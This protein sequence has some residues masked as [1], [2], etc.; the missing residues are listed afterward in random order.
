MRFLNFCCA[1]ALSVTP[2]V[3]GAEDARYLAPLPTTVEQAF[4]G[5]LEEEAATADP[6]VTASRVEPACCEATSG[7]SDVCCGDACGD[8]CCSVIGGCGCQPANCGLLGLGYLTYD[9]CAQ[10][11]VLPELLLGC[12][13]HTEGCFDDFI[14]PMTNPVF[15][16]DPRNVTELRGVFINHNV[17]AAAGGGDIQL[18]AMQIRARLTDRLSLVAG[19]DGYIVSDNPLIDDGWADVDVGLKYALY[20]DAASQRLLSVG[21]AYDMPV[22]TP[23]ALQAG[24]DGAFHLYTTGGAQILDHGHWLS[25]LGGI[26]PADQDANSSFLYWSNHFDYQVRRGW[27]ALMEFNWYHWAVDGDNRLGLTG[28][29]GGDLFN[30]GSAGVAG[31]D[32]V[33]GA[34]GVKYKPNRL[35]ELGIAW[36][37][38]LT[39]RRDV[40]EDRLTIDAIFRY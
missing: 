1:T 39:D 31:N 19:K 14:S 33:T 11:C 37:N 6:V 29:E 24:G 22:G 34:F 30:F 18:Y 17:P 40:L 20:R 4:D 27:Y 23:R 9:E 25:A 28:V 3:A 2:L 38:P 16:E 8:G 12:F 5:L 10:G 26:I 7:C 32:I 13:C 21:A 36:E 35:T 15:F